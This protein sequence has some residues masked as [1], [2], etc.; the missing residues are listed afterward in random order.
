MNIAWIYITHDMA[1]ASA[2]LSSVEKFIAAKSTATTPA[3]PD[4]DSEVP[5]SVD[6]PSNVGEDEIGDEIW[7][8]MEPVIVAIHL[9]SVAAARQLLNIARTNGV[10]NAGIR[11]ISNDGTVRLSPV[12]FVLRISPRSPLR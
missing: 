3:E 9:R 2:A 7:F 8:K 11:S 5:N 10:K 4:G 6:D 1:S 12:T